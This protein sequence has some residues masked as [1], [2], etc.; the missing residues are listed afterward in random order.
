MSHA[1]EIQAAKIERTM[2]QYHRN[3]IGQS[4]VDAGKTTALT[5]TLLQTTIHELPKLSP[6]QILHLIDMCVTYTG[7]SLGALQSARARASAMTR[8]KTEPSG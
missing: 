7:Q 8:A 2:Q 1:D 5:E 4:I 3:Q 6:E